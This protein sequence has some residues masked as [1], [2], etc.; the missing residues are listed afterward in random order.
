MFT[1]K[2]I[3]VHHSATKDSGTVSWNAIRKFHV[4]QNGWQDIGYHAGIELVGDRYECMVG[5]SITIP[6]A[7][8][9]GHNKDSLGFCFVG[10]YDAVAPNPE[11][12]AVAVDR[13]LAPWCFRFNIPIDRIYGHRQFSPKT[14]PGKLFSVDMLREMIRAAL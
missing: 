2:Q 12:L 4:E 6:G 1:P 14:C 13:V 11:M 9:E 5:R 7:H 3:V 8:C 10:D